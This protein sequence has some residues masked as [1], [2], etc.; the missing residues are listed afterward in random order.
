MVRLGSGFGSFR[1]CRKRHHGQQ[2]TRNKPARPIELSFSFSLSLFLPLFPPFSL[3]FPADGNTTFFLS[4]NDT[5]AAAFF[6]ELPGTSSVHHLLL[7]SPVSRRSLSCVY[8]RARVPPRNVIRTRGVYQG[9]SL[10]SF[11]V[12]EQPPSVTKS[13]FLLTARENV[14]QFLRATRARLATHGHTRALYPELH[15][16]RG[17]RTVQPAPHTHASSPRRFPH[18]STP[19]AFLQDCALPFWTLHTPFQA[20]NFF[21]AKLSHFCTD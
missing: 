7:L 14:A 1:K 5:L 6:L 21:N 20:W 9:D 13:R 17:D 3:S 10:F 16:S 8:T 11:A 2:D 19:S 15:S 18:H 4:L 12:A